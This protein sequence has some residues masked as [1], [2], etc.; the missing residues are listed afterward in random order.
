MGEIAEAMLDGTMCECCGEYL[1]EGD[2]CPRYCSDRCARDRGMLPA[3]DLLKQAATMVA[4][5]GNEVEKLRIC[6]V[7]GKRLKN[8]DGC[9][10]HK[11]AKHEET[12]T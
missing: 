6:D 3:E 10:Q 4:K 1:G 9:Q 12:P 5:V 2:G 8:A 7:C 11:R